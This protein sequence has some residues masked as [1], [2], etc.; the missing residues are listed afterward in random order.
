[1]VRHCQNLFT[2]SADQKVGSEAFSRTTQTLVWTNRSVYG[3]EALPRPA[4]TTKRTN[5]SVH[6]A[7][8]LSRPAQHPVWTDRSVHGILY[9]VALS[10]LPTPTAGQQVSA[11]WRSTVSPGQFNTKRGP[12][13]NG[14]GAL[15]ALPN[16]TPS[17]DQQVSARCFVTPAQHPMLAR[18]IQ[19]ASEQWRCTNRSIR[20]WGTAKTCTNIL[21]EPTGQCTVVKHVKTCPSNLRGPIG[22]W[23]LVRHCQ[24]LP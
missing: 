6:G 12:T 13:G 20:W 22:Q 18:S 10:A 16:S 5:R 11:P 24:D 1:M 15:L 2:S 3:G 19:G 7:E 8:T 14:G 9:I 23:T 17:V 4:R 21:C